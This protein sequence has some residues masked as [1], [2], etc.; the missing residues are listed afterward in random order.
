MQIRFAQRFHATMNLRCLFDRVVCIM[1]S[2]HRSRRIR[3][4]VR[5]ESIAR[6]VDPPPSLN[7]LLNKLNLKRRSSGASCLSTLTL[8]RVD[9]PR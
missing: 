1:M 6:K 2:S 7:V 4:V 9:P 3:S 8:L 5:E